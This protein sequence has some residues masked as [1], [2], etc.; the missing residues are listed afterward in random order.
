MFDWLTPWILVPSLLVSPICQILLFAYIGRSAGVGDDEFYV[1]G[2]ALN[3][4]AIPCLFAMAFTIEGEREAQH[5]RD[6]AHHAGPPDP[7]VP[8]PGP[9]GDRSTA[10]ASRCSASSSA[11]LLLDARRPRLGV[12]AARC[13]SSWSTSAVVH[14]ARAWPWARSRCAS[15][16]ARC[17][18]TSFFC[19][20]LV[21]CGVNVALDDLPGWM[22]AVGHWLP[23]T[24][25]IEAARML[26]DGSD[27]RAAVAAA[28]SLHASSAD[29][30][31]CYARRRAGAR[32]GCFERDCS[33]RGAS[34]RP[35][36][37][38]SRLDRAVARTGR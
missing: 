16:R 21:F 30:Q 18:A 11:C 22:A 32:C 37:E 38:A 26:A 17:W 23:L 1:I 29:R 2:N 7:A 14:R 4:A 27:L 33:R 28:W 35:R 34:P 9:A 20:L 36:S 25:G 6:R 10:G 31:R 3:Y 5:A 13:S 19:V 8:R 12:A 15:A 24:H